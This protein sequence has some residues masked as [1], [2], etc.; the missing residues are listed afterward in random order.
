MTT[1]ITDEITTR[2]DAIEGNSA[3][4]LLG[5]LNQEDVLA[6]NVRLS[7]RVRQY[8]RLLAERAD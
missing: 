5:E 6:S 7:V 4:A 1:T 8:V 3:N 2:L